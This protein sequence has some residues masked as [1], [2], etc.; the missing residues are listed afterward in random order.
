[1]TQRR[2]KNSSAENLKIWDLAAGNKLLY[3]M[4]LCRVKV[5]TYWA[6]R[7]GKV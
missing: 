1:M 6:P 7:S 5:I 2:L 4:F 3:S